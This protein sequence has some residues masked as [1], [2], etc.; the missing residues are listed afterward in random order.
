VKTGKADARL[1]PPDSFHLSAAV[2][3][4][5]LGNLAEAEAELESIAPEHRRHFA[6]LEA[7]WLLC[8]EARD[9]Q[10]GLE[11]AR[12]MVEVAADRPEGW[13]HQAYAIRRAPG[14]GLEQAWMILR[15]AAAVF[16][17]NKLIPFNLACYACQMGR[18]AE[19][20]EWIEKAF[21][22]GGKKTMK[23]M[24]LEDEDLR[25]LWDQIRNL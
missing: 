13:L 22:T 3:W 25:P 14:G 17:R 19:A 11:V 18:T 5:E 7:R 4:M 6:V 16:P 24:A 1:E 10:R 15:S 21:E 8:A 20:R 12:E 2:G 23:A 9:W